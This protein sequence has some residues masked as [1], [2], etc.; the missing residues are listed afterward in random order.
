MTAHSSLAGLVL[1]LHMVVIAFNVFGLVAIPLGAWRGWSFVRIAWWRLMHVA[2]FAVVAAQ[3]VTGR[4]CFLTLWQDDLSGA[5]ESTP[6]IAR[7]VNSVIFWPLPIWVFAAAYVALALYVVALLWIV[8]VRRT[9]T[10][11]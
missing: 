7:W 11:A 9:K 10:A 2:S 1:A 3:A 4:A 6:M 5:A 8:P